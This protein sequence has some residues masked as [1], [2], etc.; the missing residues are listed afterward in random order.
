MTDDWEKFDLNLQ[1]NFVFYFFFLQMFA[2]VNVSWDQW[3]PK[4][5]Q[6]TGKH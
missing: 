5:T 4:S 2:H 3:C 6:L 1:V